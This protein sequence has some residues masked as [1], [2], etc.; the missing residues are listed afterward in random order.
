M[1]VTSRSDIVSAFRRCYK[2]RE[3]ER[4][5]QTHGLLVEAEHGRAEELRPLPEDLRRRGPVVRRRCVVERR[6]IGESSS[7]G[8]ILAGH[9]SR[10]SGEPPLRGQRGRKP[11]EEKPFHGSRRGTPAFW[12]HGRRVLDASFPKRTSRQI[13]PLSLSLSVTAELAFK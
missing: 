7:G 3:R 6:H 2:E 5:R 1:K 13:T 12:K 10:R 4:G 8:S 11:S 9:C